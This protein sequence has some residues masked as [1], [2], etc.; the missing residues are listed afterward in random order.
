MKII[1]VRDGFIKFEADESIYL[2]SFVQADG[3]DKSYI[4]QVNHIR[5]IGNVSIASAKILFISINGQLS[6]YDKT[7]PSKDAELK[8]FTADILTNSVNAKAPVI[9]GKTLDN[10]LNIIAD[11]DAFDK[12]TLISVD[13]NEL[14]NILVRNLSKQF[15]NLGKKTVVFDTL[16][17]INA[18]KCIAG[19]DFKL[20]LDTNTL[21]FMYKSCLSDVT[22]E[23]KS[24][25]VE[26]FNDLSEYSKTVPFVPFGVLKSIVDEMVDKQHVFK[27]LVLKNKLAKFEKLG[28]FATQKSEVDNLKKLLETDCL[29]IDL[30]KIDSLFGGSYIEYVYETLKNY[31]VQ[32][33][34]EVSNTVSKRTL[35]C[36][37]LDSP[38]P[39]TIITHSKFRYLSDIK[40]MFDN[41][42]IEPSLANNSIFK[43]YSSFLTSMDKKTYLTVGEAI[44]YIPMV[45][46]AQIID[47]VISYE[48]EIEEEQDLQIEEEDPPYIEDAEPETEIETETKTETDED[49]F[50]SPDMEDEIIAEQESE[51]ESENKKEELI[52]GINEKSEEAI[53]AISESFEYEED[54]DVF[55]ED[56]SVEES[57]FEEEIMELPNEEIS[58]QEVTEQDETELLSEEED[59][60]E[61]DYT[62]SEVAPENQ[63]EDIEETQIQ[64]VG[65]FVEDAEE[66]NL[67]DEQEESE[68]LEYQEDEEE[69]ISEEI[70]DFNSED[71]GNDIEENLGIEA[72]DDSDELLIQL[73]SEEEQ[74]I[75]DDAETD[76]VSDEKLLDEQSFESND[77]FQ[78]LPINDSELAEEL[79]DI[80]ELSPDE[81]D[82]NDI[83][84]DMADENENIILDDDAERQIKED[85]DKV[86]TTVKE[87]NEE[88]SD[89]DLDFIDELNSGEDGELS[90]EYSDDLSQFAES[91]DL[92]EG[93][94]D[95][96]QESIIPERKHVPNE[97]EILE[98]RESNTP[99]VP[100]YDADIPQEDMVVSD[101]IQQGD[102][103]VHAKYGNGVVEKMIKY[104]NKTLFS[105]NFENIGRR[106][107]DP[108]LTEI[109]KL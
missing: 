87:D 99:I 52:A 42:I 7:E 14:N 19:V 62:E 11:A 10:S 100:V 22:A 1:E 65:E 38:V 41:F 51:Q 108:T 34:F 104:G 92:E 60:I 21:N 9:I 12:K 2:S 78:I 56:E 67:T 37:M 81:T 85:V 59:I 88:I 26:I 15:N 31:E 20:P 50:V 66:N 53:D 76:Q 103:V 30:S 49:D 28:Y 8:P 90:E 45:S 96:P 80:I 46:K 17:V 61:P 47:D 84:I 71:R 54:I 91:S 40:N 94:L 3:L 27:L 4:A 29:I 18:K 25:I 83:I 5:C 75:Q 44:N 57:S 32:V 82:D 55:G 13:D 69:S 63:K 105:I 77:D 36:A 58:E 101:P 86:Y 39:T 70:E 93:I 74:L 97:P 95:Q 68:L 6:N 48:S 64:E 24:T 107:L 72:S 79:D 106:L 102:S 89:S 109:K 16:G 73:D 23:S 35:K 33:L 98:K 43:V